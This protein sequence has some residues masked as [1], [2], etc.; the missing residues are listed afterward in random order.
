MW[1]HEQYLVHPLTR[2]E[3][4]TKLL[5]A[6]SLNRCFL[7]RIGA[8]S[9][10]V[11]GIDL[12]DFSLISMGDDPSVRKFVKTGKYHSFYSWLVH[13][14]ETMLFRV[15]PSCVA[16]LPALRGSSISQIHSAG[17][18][19]A[20]LFHQCRMHADV[21]QDTTARTGVHPVELSAGCGGD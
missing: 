11:A 15:A 2:V 4:V 17:S 19:V 20:V 10:P 18:R 9:M 8:L 16:C 14:M 3:V 21:S 5:Y 1:T 7:D 6:V 13:V 12:L